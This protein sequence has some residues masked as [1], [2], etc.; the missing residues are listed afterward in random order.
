[1]AWRFDTNCLGIVSVLTTGPPKVVHEIIFLG[2]WMTELSSLSFGNRIAPIGIV[3][4][5]V[6][7]SHILFTIVSLQLILFVG[8][9]RSQSRSIH[10]ISLIVEVVASVIRILKIIHVEM[11]T[12]DSIGVS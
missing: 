5:S 2:H 8:V 3:K 11:I 6:M 10:V 12:L 7:T 1:M 9:A 4:Y